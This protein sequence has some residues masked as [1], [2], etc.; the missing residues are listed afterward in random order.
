MKTP[1]FTALDYNIAYY[2]LFDPSSIE[3]N[4]TFKFIYICIPHMLVFVTFVVGVI[5]R[6]K[7]KELAMRSALWNYAYYYLSYKL[8]I[9]TWGIMLTPMFCNVAQIYHGYTI[10]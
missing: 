2:L 10:F 8:F 9:L 1:L 7:L 5:S 4:E 3:N 6:L